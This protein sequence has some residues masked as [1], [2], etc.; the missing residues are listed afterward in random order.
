M[1]CMRLYKEILK[2]KKVKRLNILSRSWEQKEGHT[3]GSIY[4]LTATVQ[5]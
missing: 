3:Q 2:Y 5:I 1:F 4:R